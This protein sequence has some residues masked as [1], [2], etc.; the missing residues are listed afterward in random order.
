M[1][2]I[3]TYELDTRFDRAKSFYNKAIITETKNTIKLT[4]YETDIVELDKKTNKLKWL[5]NGEWAFTQTTNRHINE[6]LR[7]FTNEQPKTKQQLLK[8]ANAK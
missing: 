6:F 8:L 1:N 5:V 2:N 4:S 3:Y 7:Q